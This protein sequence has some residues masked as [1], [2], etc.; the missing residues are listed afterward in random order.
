MFERCFF[1]NYFLTVLGLCFWVFV[2]GLCF[3]IDFSLVA[4]SKGSSL[5]Q[6][7]GFSLWWFLLLRSSGSRACTSVV[8]AFRLNSCS[9]Q[10]SMLCGTWD[11]PGSGIKSGHWQVDS[12]PLSHQGSPK[13]SLNVKFFKLFFFLLLFV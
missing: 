4:A 9:G 11:L 5:L 6:C 2:L 1:F 12:L 8:V 13:T 7:V 3:C 10:S